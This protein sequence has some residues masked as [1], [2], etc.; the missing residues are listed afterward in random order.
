MVLGNTERGG[1][2]AFILNL[3]K[4]IDLNRFQIDLA[5]NTDIGTGGIGDDVRQFGCKTYLF[6]TEYVSRMTFNCWHEELKEYGKD[7]NFNGVG[8]HGQGRS[9]G[10]P[11]KPAYKY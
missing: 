9:T 1:T 6:K 4:N 10:F 8:Y 11:A 5:V 7:K 3:L 2:Q